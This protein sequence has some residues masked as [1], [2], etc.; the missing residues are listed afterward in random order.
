MVGVAMV[1]ERL[2]TINE[3]V[4]EGLKAYVMVERAAV[5]FPNVMDALA[6]NGDVPVAASLTKPSLDDVYLFYTGKRYQIKEDAS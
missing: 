5:L 3:S 6:H 1:L 4:V 2:S